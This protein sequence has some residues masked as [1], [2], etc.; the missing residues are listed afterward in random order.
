[1]ELSNEDVPNINL[2][3]EVPKL[4]GVDTSTLKRYTQEMDEGRRTM[5]LEVDT[6]T[7]D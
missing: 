3:Q 1:M 4:P 2:C 6:E 5:Q 7:M